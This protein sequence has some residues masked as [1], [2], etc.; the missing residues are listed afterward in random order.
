MGTVMLTHIQVLGITDKG[1]ILGLMW[2][3][4]L[5]RFLVMTPSVYCAFLATELHCA[6]H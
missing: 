5:F 2:N 1:R 4:H 3:G 6:V